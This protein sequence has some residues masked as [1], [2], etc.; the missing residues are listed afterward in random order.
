MAA[1]AE[2]FASLRGATKAGEGRP[3]RLILKLADGREIE[4]AAKGAFPA[5]P[6]ARAALKAARG[7]ERVA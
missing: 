5:S 4:I 1:L 3:L 6:A 2:T 7:V